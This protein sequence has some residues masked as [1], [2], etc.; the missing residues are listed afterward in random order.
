[1]FIR[2]ARLSLIQ[3]HTQEN[4]LELTKADWSSLADRT[5]G[6]SGSDIANMTLG[7]LFGPI[8]DLRATQWWW[9]S[10]GTKCSH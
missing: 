4:A 10:P 1:M 5:E 7:A 8:R 2:E 3:I 9:K 6:Y